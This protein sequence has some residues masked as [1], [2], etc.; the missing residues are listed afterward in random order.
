MTEE[1]EGAVMIMHPAREALL[2]EIHARPFLPVDTPQ[3]FIHYGFI[4]DDKSLAADREW[5]TRF[6]LGHGVPGPD[7]GARHHIVPLGRGRLRWE[8]HAEFITYTYS[9]PIENGKPF[10]TEPENHPFGTTFRAPGKLLVGTRLD[11]VSDAEPL[12]GLLACFDPSSLAASEVEQGTAICATDFRPDRHGRTRI[13]I[14]NRR[15]E[16]NRAGVLVQRLLEIETYRLLCLLGLPEAQRLSP[17]VERIENGLQE[18]TNAIRT[19]DGLQSNKAL[20]D[21]LS[22]LAADLEAGAAETSFRFGASRAY[23][24]IVEQRLKVL[25]ETFLPGFGTWQVFLARRLAPAMRTC[26]AVVQRQINLSRKLA[27]ATDLLRTRINVEVE[28]QNSDLLKS[29]NRRTRMQ[30]RMQQTVEGLSV[31][32][33]SYYVVGLLAYIIKGT[34]ALG[35]PV[36]TGVLTAVSVVPVIAVISY[37]VWRIRAHHADPDDR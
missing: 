15:L 28:Q 11:L 5:L 6:C 30:L 25:G 27:R 9:G 3:A 8:R 16:A 18:V 29:M 14:V 10:G 32:A 22:Q 33:I 4:V 12:D 31:A 35:L 13:L 21:R 23:N 24:E 34:D 26:E 20:L 1:F 19:A 2:G 36:D 17:E 37:L 7:E